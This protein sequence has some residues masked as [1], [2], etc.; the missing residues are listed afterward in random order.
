MRDNF[1]CFYFQTPETLSNDEQR[2]LLDEYNNGNMEARDKLIKYNIRFVMFIV[3]KYFKDAPY[4]KKDLVSI[5]IRGLEKAIDTYNWKKNEKFAGYSFKCIYNEIGMF[6]RKLRKDEKVDSLDRIIFDNGQP[7]RLMD[8]I[9]DE[10]D[11][12]LNIEQKEVN[13][14]I[15]EV[16]ENLS[17]R[18][19]K[20]IEMAFGFNGTI[21]SQKEISRELK[22]SQGNISRILKKVLND[23]KII[24]EEYEIIEKKEKGTAAKHGNIRSNTK[25][26]LYEFF[27]NYSREHIDKLVESLTEK[28]IQL[29]NYRF[30]GDYKNGSPVYLDKEELDKFY[31]LVGKIKKKL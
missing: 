16:V 18:E 3:R 13:R 24:F 27:S 9:S 29:I 10:N 11:I 6:L 21:Y 12:A 28:E 1:L 2:I 8:V 15:R 17:P 25:K 5:G 19:R 30:G 14:I 22:R 20:I 23:L 4:D 26:T 7:I 31:R